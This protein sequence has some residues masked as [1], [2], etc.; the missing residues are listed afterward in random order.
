MNKKPEI[1][2]LATSVVHELR[3][4][5]GVIDLAVYNL[6]REKGDLADNKHLLN[7]EKNVW[8]ANY[9]VT[10]FL[11]YMRIKEPSYVKVPIVD[12]LDQCILSVQDIL[13]DQGIIID[14]QYDKTLP[15]IEADSN[16][17][18]DVFFNILIN[19]CQS[20][21][22]SGGN[23]ELRVELKETLVQVSIQD[24]GPGIVKELGLDMLLCHELVN[25]HQG[26]IEIIPQ[27]GLGTKVIVLL[28]I[29]HKDVL[30]EKG[31]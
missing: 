27:K 26:K 25:L 8:E 24:A 23:I 30:V 10:N 20:L 21:K 13:G 22:K 6:K 28:P 9:M 7:I 5:L 19:A 18:R 12:L 14:K 2:Q 4:Q 3:N 16:Q 1:F 15:C 31:Q 11:S 29:H 17:I